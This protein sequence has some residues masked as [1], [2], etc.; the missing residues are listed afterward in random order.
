MTMAEVAVFSDLPGIDFEH[1]HLPHVWGQ[2]DYS[3]HS[4]Y[5]YEGHHATVF[6]MKSP[7]HVSTLL[8]RG[9]E[10]HG[11]HEHAV[12][13]VRG[14]EHHHYQR[15]P[16]SLL[17]DGLMTPGLS[18]TALSTDDNDAESDTTRSQ[19]FSTSH[20]DDVPSSDGPYYSSPTMNYES[21]PSW[22]QA[23]GSMTAGHTFVN[24]TQVCPD[25]TSDQKHTLIEHC[26]G[27][28][29]LHAGP[30]SP[31]EQDWCEV[32]ARGPSVEP[33]SDEDMNS[34]DSFEEP[35][36]DDDDPPYNPGRSKASQRRRRPSGLT[37]RT[38]AVRQRQTSH[39][40][41]LSDGGF[42]TVKSRNAGRGFPCLLAHYGCTATFANKNEWKR[43]SSTQHVKLGLWRCD[44]CPATPQSSYNDFNRKDLFTQHLKRM[45]RQHIVEKYDPEK[46]D[47]YRDV[48]KI[49]DKE[50]KE[51]TEPLV[52]SCWQELRNLPTKCRCLFC[53]KNFKGLTAWD[54]RME[55]LAGHLEKY[56]KTGAK[57]P[58]T[59]EWK[60]DQELEV[61]LE[62]E[63]LIEMDPKGKWQIGEGRPMRV[64]S[65]I[66][67]R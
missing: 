43:H 44:L 24:P 67:S 21:L 23:H 27:G 36:S 19:M 61:W 7:Y 47:M 60:E 55:H 26:S 56:R 17:V 16:P 9:V 50:L 2:S 3:V 34:S 25:E 12:Q 20:F 58:G 40:K 14:G 63:N 15:Y 59:H 57:V 11:Q 29:T 48:N 6:V 8:P 51:A 42:T 53:D 45:H 64:D 22:N 46:L 39:R 52:R 4:E 35:P 49:H 38:K 18:P 31:N 5:P 65:K 10:R 37:K 13:Y 28:T 1:N 62:A 33:D 30:Q 54:N 32:E 41:S 66:K